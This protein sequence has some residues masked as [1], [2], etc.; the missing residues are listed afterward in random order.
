VGP[1]P[2]PEVIGAEYDV[3]TLPSGKTQTPLLQ[4]Y[5]SEA[6]SMKSGCGVAVG[7]A[8]GGV[9]VGC[10]RWAAD[11]GRGTARTS[12]NEV[13]ARA[14]ASLL[15][16]TSLLWLPLGEDRLLSRETHPHKGHLGDGY[17]M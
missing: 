7:Y 10:A 12:S 6:A 3:F 4:L 2:P 1:E 8:A 5:P 13:T 15:F 14:A 16:I 17:G 9:G 11:M